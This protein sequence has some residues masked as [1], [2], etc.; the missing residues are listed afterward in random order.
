VDEC[1][2]ES[3]GISNYEL[4]QSESADYVL[5]FVPDG[6][7]P[8]E[9]ELRRVT[10]RLEALLAVRAEIKTE[11]LTVLV[12]QASGKFRLTCPAPVKS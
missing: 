2:S 3:N 11:A 1:F 4:R 5:R 10:A 8:A 12:P 7:G 9:T 6:T